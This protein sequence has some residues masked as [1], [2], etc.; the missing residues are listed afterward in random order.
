MSQLQLF[1]SSK[2]INVPSEGFA[3]QNVKHTQHNVK[4]DAVVSRSFFFV[5]L[6]QR[7]SAGGDQCAGWVVVSGH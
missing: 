7:G 3:K 4:H 6:A 5:A 2:F 1:H